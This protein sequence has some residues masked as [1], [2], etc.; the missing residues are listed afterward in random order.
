[1]CLWCQKNSLPFVCLPVAVIVKLIVGGESD[2]ASPSS[3]QREKDLSGCIF[4]HL[5]QKQGEEL[6]VNNRKGQ[7]VQKTSRLN[8]VSSARY[9]CIIQFLPFWC[10]K[11]EDAIKGTGQGHSSD[12]QD[13]QH[14][15]GKCGCEINHLS[16]KDTRKKEKGT[17]F[18]FITNDS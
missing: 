13:D 14:H 3:R 12:Q 6:Q 15:I 5:T 7:T 11:V 8:Q 18:F 4:P 9:L 2:E 1:M 10:D 17:R 16:K